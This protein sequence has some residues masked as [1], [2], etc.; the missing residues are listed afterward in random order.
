MA[1]PKTP[2]QNKINLELK[3]INPNFKA[4]T[5]IQF[6]TNK[7]ALKLQNMFSDDYFSDTNALTLKMK[8]HQER[9]EEIPPK[10]LNEF[11]TIYT[12]LMHERNKL[13]EDVGKQSYYNNYVDTAKFFGLPFEGLFNMK[14]IHRLDNSIYSD[15][16]NQH[17]NIDTENTFNYTKE[18]K[19]S[20]QE[21]TNCINEWIDYCKQLSTYKTY[22]EKLYPRWNKM[23]K[24]EKKVYINELKTLKEAPFITRTQEIDNFLHFLENYSLNQVPKAKIEKLLFYK[25]VNV[26]NY[27]IAKEIYEKTN[28]IK[29]GLISVEGFGSL[30]D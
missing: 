22:I 12:S 20:I 29:K 26:D 30:E 18:R 10:L 6:R 25:F 17:I 15:V 8:E 27:K 19:E 5:E 11:I 1:I 7:Y 9:K 28:L 3:K 13:L 14:L 24:K 2:L 23:T 4:F 16:I 21:Y